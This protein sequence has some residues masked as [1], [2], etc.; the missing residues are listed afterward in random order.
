MSKKLKIGPAW[1]GTPKDAERLRDISPLEW[2]QLEG[3]AID[4][5]YLELLST[6]EGL[7]KLQLHRTSVT[8]AGLAHLKKAQQLQSLA[9]Q[10]T[11]L[12]DVSLQHLKDMKLSAL[13]LYGTKIS[14]DAAMSFQEKVA[15]MRVDY[16]NG[17]FLGVRAHSIAI[18]AQGEGCV[19][20]TVEDNSAADKAGLRFGDTILKYGDKPVADFEELKNLIARNHPGDKIP[21][22]IKRG[23]KVILKNVE[24]GEWQLRDEQ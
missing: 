15:G 3:D 6:I 7:T 20:G 23:K 5:K 18:P 22:E 17:A 2:V 13:Y 16:R 21:L 19:L 4:D 11:P 1:I 9:I 24:L 14:Y 8:D 12:T 10:Y